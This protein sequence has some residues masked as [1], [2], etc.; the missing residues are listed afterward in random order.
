M[1]DFRKRRLGVLPGE[2]EKKKAKAPLHLGALEIL[3]NGFGEF[4]GF[5]VEA[6]R[7]NRRY[8][9]GWTLAKL[10]WGCSPFCGDFSQFSISHLVHI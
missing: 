4:S 9:A 5:L 1:S 7:F 8:A 6:R 2:R 10:M 3:A